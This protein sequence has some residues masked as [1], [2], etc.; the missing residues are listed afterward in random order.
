MSTHEMSYS[1]YQ[2]GATLRRQDGVFDHAGKVLVTLEKGVNILPVT[3]RLPINRRIAKEH[4]DVPCICER[5]I[6]GA[7][8][9]E[10]LLIDWGICGDR[11]EAIAPHGSKVAIGDWLATE[12][13]IEERLIAGVAKLDHNRRNRVR[14]AWVMHE[15][16]QKVSKLLDAVEFT[17]RDKWSLGKGVQ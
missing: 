11:P 2:Q 15:R 3:H 12:E 16:D 6:D 1:R 14:E 13:A 10:E 4:T 5:A 17:K 7:H 9:A 8:S